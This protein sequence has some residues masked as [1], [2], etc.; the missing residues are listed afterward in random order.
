MMQA[1]NV[2]GL[3]VTLAQRLAFVGQYGSVI[4]CLRTDTASN[5]CGRWQRLFDSKEYISSVPFIISFLA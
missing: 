3:T 4:T 5:P 1:V 2:G